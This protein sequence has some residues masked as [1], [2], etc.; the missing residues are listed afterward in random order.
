MLKNLNLSLN[1]DKTVCVV[2]RKDNKHYLDPVITLGNN[3][4][5]VKKSYKYLG[6]IL[7]NRLSNK[8]DILRSE[9][10]FLKQFFAIFRRF[11]FCDKNV[12]IHNLNLTV[13]HY[14][15]KSCGLT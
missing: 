1:I 14:M 9:A 12:L 15:E 2:F 10:S 7:S 8:E 13:Y 11:H 3:V 5:R 6:I 4:I